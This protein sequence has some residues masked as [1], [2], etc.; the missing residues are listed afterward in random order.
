LAD[1]RKIEDERDARQCLSKA[2]RAGL[3]QGEWAR[4]HGISGRSLRAWQMNI[5]K[6]GVP[7]RRGN[8]RPKPVPV[9]TAHALVELVPAMPPAVEKAT[10]YALVVGDA[11]VEFGDDVS[12][13]T[14]RRVFEALRSC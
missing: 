9:P 3:S 12:A 4:A 1:G 8:P 13:A 10:R 14:L 11:R 5:G 7:W 6:R 2:A